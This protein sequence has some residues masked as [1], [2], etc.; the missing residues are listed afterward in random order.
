[1]HEQS[2]FYSPFRVSMHNW[3]EYLFPRSCYGC[4]KPWA[5]LCF[6]CKKELFPHPEL[7]PFC[8]KESKNFK[9]C[10]SCRFEGSNF[11]D[12]LVV[13]FSYKTLLKKLI[14]KLKFHHKSDIAGFLAER[15]ALLTQLNPDLTLAMQ[16]DQLFISFV[17]SHRYRKYFQKGYNQSELLA[18]ELATQLEIPRVPCFKKVKAT[19]SQV[20]LTRSERLKNLNAAFVFLPSAISLLPQNATL[21]IVD[22]VT[23]T[24][25]TLN[26][27]AKRAKSSRPDLHIRGLVLVRHT[28]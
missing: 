27:L 17:P 22:D 13:G 9:T 3:L 16:K 25:A 8:H 12:G 20:K 28:G 23:T 2:S 10:S 19:T 18:K 6:E 14:L 1:M 24:W 11:L 5:Y 21:L 7:C 15:G 4:D 26:E